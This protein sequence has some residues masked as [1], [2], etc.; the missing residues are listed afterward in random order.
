M[1]DK[2]MRLMAPLLYLALVLFVIFDRADYDLSRVVRPPFLVY[3]L[4]AAVSYIVLRKVVN[5]EN[6][7]DSD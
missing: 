6:S 7:S 1:K 3:V 5:E 2:L 4:M